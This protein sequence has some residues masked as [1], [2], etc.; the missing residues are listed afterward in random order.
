[1]LNKN[2]P[3]VGSLLI[4]EPFMLDPNFQRSVIL[5]TQHDEEGTIGYVLNQPTSLCLSDVMHD[6]SAG[7]PFP[8]YF[9]GPVAQD[10]IHF[11]HKHALLIEDAEIIGDKGL[12]WG[13]NFDA[14]KDLIEMG[15][16]KHEEIK[17][18]I[19]YS[20]WSPGQLEEEIHSNAWM[21]CNQYPPELVLEHHADHLWKEALVVMGPKF[22]HVAHFPQNP[23][24]N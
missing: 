19:G 7:D 22:A 4:S 3:G 15:L 11:I 9:G 10:S 18:L 8:L 24:W 2:K 20:G 16:V 12:Y 23:Q 1:M 21:I 17:F 6:F 5:I 14:L 13:G